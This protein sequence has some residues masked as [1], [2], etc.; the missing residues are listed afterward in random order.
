MIDY[1][2]LYQKIYFI[3]PQFSFPE[4]IYKNQTENLFLRA[5][6]IEITVFKVK[7]IKNTKFFL[8]KLPVT[9]EVRQPP[10]NHCILSV[11]WKALI[12]VMILG[13]SS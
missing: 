4:K 2:M 11:Y 12:K 3:S 7:V 8:P 10:I 5:R 13:L 6:A 9:D 1:N